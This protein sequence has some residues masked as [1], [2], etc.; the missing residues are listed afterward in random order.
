[1]SLL[2]FVFR[3]K[4]IKSFIFKNFNNIFVI[5]IFFRIYILLLLP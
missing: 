3:F 5:D 2:Y 1:M 4:T